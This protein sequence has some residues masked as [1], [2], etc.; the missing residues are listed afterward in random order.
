MWETSENN[1]GNSAPRAWRH[2]TLVSLREA[3]SQQL[4]P[5]ASRDR[6]AGTHPD[7]AP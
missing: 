4:L 7:V 6:V 2:K 1:I 5:A 3:D